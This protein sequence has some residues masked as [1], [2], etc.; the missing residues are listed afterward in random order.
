MSEAYT[1]VKTGGGKA[2]QFP[3]VPAMAVVV[4]LCICGG[5]GCGDK[6]GERGIERPVVTG[7][8]VTNVGTTMAREVYE[9]TG[10][11]RSER[12]SIV[13]SRVL[14]VVTSLHVR[15]G[16]TVKSGQLLLTLDDRD[17]AER[18]NA[19]TQALESAR[20]NL[21]LAEVTWRRY[22]GLFEQKVIAGQEMD[23]IENRHNVAK[24]EY[25][26]SRAMAEEAR[27]YLGF[28]RITSPGDGVVAE[29]RTDAGSM[30]VPGIPL[31]VIEGGGGSHVEV[32]VDEGLTR[33][34]RTGMPV[35]VT[36]DAL[37]KRFQGKVRE[38]L[39]AV[40]PAS[41]TFLVK[42]GLEGSR[43]RS[44]LFARVRFPAGTREKILVPGSAIVRKGQLTGVYVVDGK[45][46]IT[47]RLIRTGSASAAGTE[48]L[49]GL[50]PGERIITGGIERVVDG[51][52]FKEKSQ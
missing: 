4:A 8:T 46:L 24:A 3:A 17:A 45:R 49:S 52:I 21:G 18:L 28:S 50:M 37:E 20:Q 2:R 25:E 48:V 36:I 1:R 30:A 13:A 34:I 42:I 19:A 14:A 22:H 12:T 10:T 39:P 43:P 47:Y 5:A 9:A 32:A 11:V 44:G 7:V 27:T 51:G 40:D 38:I 16:D 41:R 6:H 35:E 31:L 15:E 33:E 23:Q 26:R 29:K